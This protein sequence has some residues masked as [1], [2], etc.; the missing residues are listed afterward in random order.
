MV[1]KVGVVRHPTHDAL[2]FAY[3]TLFA[4][5]FALFNSALTLVNS[6]FA[7]YNGGDGW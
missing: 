7:L 2:S 6:A 5:A 1:Y 4:S 3:Y